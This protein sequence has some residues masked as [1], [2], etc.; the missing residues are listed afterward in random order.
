MGMPTSAQ[1]EQHSQAGIAAIVG[2]VGIGSRVGL[3]V[4]GSA[5]AEGIASPGISNSS[6]G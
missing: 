1:S 4:E 5:V 2:G 6:P 3:G